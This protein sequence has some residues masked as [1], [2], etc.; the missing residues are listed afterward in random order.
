MREAL[1]RL[2]GES[3]VYGL[4][5]VSGRAVSLLLVPV[6]TRVLPPDVYGVSEL[7]LAYSQT[8]LL[9][10][11]FGMDAALARFFYQEPDREARIRMVSSSLVFRIATG[12]TAALLI[13][14]VAA[15]LSTHLLGGAV[16]RKYLLL[17]AV[18]I[19]FTLLVLF[20]NDVLRVTFQPWKFIALNLAQMLVVGGMTLYLVIGRDLGVA[21]VLYAK[22]AGDAVAAGLGLL[23]CRHAIRPRPSRETLGRM[24]RYGIPLVPVAFA[25]GAITSL[26]R[27][28][29]QRTRSLEEVG[30]YA[31]AIKFFAVVTIGVSAFQ[32]A[33]GPFAFARAAMPE[34]PRLYARVLALYVAVAS[35]AALLVGVFAP[36]IVGVLAPAAYREAARPAL[37]LAFAAVAQGAYYVAALGI[38]LSLKTWLLGWTAGGAALVSIVL[39]LALTPGS[40]PMGAAIA[41]WAAYLASATLAYVVAQREQPMPYRGLRMLGVFGFALALAVAAQTW[42]P[43]GGAGVG[44]KLGA[45][46]AFVAVLFRLE[47]WRDRGA[48]KAGAVPPAPSTA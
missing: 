42:A 32:L 36:E 22:L 3:L 9:V 6:L 45:A 25:Y 39:N 21:G 40:G 35:L 10:L 8:V 47:V 23:L 14:A 1:K 41:T 37:W 2:S 29:L 48:V 34:A 11:V 44:V 18:T 7:V 12:V 13:V 30:V 15:P 46:V 28:V 19:P 24:L 20:A 38:N 16:Y 17:G 26:D 27:F 5:Q 33:F 31:V 4:G 43:P